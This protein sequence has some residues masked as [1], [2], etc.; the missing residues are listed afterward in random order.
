MVF[1]A[2]KVGEIE[3]LEKIHFDLQKRTVYIGA[4]G[5]GESRTLKLSSVQIYHL[6]EHILKLE[7]DSLLGYPLQNQ[8]QALC[9]QLREINPKVRNSTHLRGSRISYW[10]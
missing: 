1:Q 7:S 9:K 10:G 2:M 5:I 3:R 6:M 8:A 4:A